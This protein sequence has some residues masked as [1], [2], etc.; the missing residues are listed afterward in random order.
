M[1]DKC[2]IEGCGH[3]AEEGSALCWV[4]N[5]VLPSS[6]LDGVVEFCDGV[7]LVDPE[8]IEECKRRSRFRIEGFMGR[9]EWN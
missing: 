8:K 6:V 3:V 2:V 5:D 1:V 7:F 9:A 4:C